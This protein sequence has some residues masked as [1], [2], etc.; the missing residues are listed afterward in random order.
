M[1]KPKVK[2]TPLPFRCERP[3]PVERGRHRAYGYDFFWNFFGIH[4]PF[5]WAI[6]LGL[7]FPGF[8]GLLQA[9]RA[10]SAGSEVAPYSGG[11]VKMDDDDF[12]E[13]Q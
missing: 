11:G 3:P 12:G 5:S 13:D 8:F 2:P 6:F 1:S 10:A 4:P 9:R 7:P